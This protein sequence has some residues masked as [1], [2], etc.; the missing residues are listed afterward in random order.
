MQLMLLG[1]SAC[2]QGADA[3]AVVDQSGNIS[4]AKLR[5]GPYFEPMAF[6]APLHSHIRF[7]SSLDQVFF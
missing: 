1:D 4:S 6:C 2:I 5:R 3:V 7:S